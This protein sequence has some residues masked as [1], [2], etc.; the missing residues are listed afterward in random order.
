[1]AAGAAAPMLEANPLTLR[2]MS[3]MMNAAPQSLVAAGFIEIDMPDG[4]RPQ[5]SNGGPHGTAMPTGTARSTSA[6][7]SGSPSAGASGARAHVL[8]RTR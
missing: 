5:E 7:P 4:H 3:D 6:P 2:A 1:M 8:W